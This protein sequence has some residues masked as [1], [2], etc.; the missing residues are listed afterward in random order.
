MDI[1]WTDADADP[2]FAKI[3]AAGADY[4]IHAPLALEYERRLRDGWVMVKDQLA[5]VADAATRRSYF[6][7]GADV[8]PWGVEYSQN[9]IHIGSSLDFSDP[10]WRFA[11]LNTA[12]LVLRKLIPEAAALSPWPVQAVVYVNSPI[13]TVEDV[14]GEATVGGV[15]FIL[16][17]PNEGFDLRAALH[18]PKTTSMPIA[19]SAVITTA[20]DNAGTPMLDREAR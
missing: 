11:I 19:P 4:L 8:P 12:L 14:D 17:R 1:W 15:K 7:R 13:G 9:E 2:E 10:T 18:E 20:F 16:L 3:V 6:D 5:F